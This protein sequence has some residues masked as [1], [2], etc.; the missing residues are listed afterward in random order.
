[1]PIVF[2]NVVEKE[3]DTTVEDSLGSG[4]L[5]PDGETV[6]LC[7]SA[8]KTNRQNK[9]NTMRPIIKTFWRLHLVYQ[10]LLWMPLVGSIAICAHSAQNGPASE[11]SSSDMWS[12]DNVVQLLQ[13]VAIYEKESREAETL[14]NAQRL[15]VDLD[16]LQQR[17]RKWVE[18]KSILNELNIDIEKQSNLNKE[19]DEIQ[20]ETDTF[21]KNG[22]SQKPPYT[23]DFFDQLKGEQD[24]LQQTAKTSDLALNTVKQS[25]ENALAGLKETQKQSRQ[26]QEQFEGNDT[27]SAQWQ[28][29][30]VQLD[31][32]LVE[33]RYQ[34]ERWKERNLKT[35]QQALAQRNRLLEEQASWIKQRLTYIPENLTRHEQALGEKQ[36]ELQKTLSLLAKKKKDADQNWIKAQ[37]EAQKP[38]SVEVKS[39]QQAVLKNMDQW[40]KTYQTAID[41]TTDMLHLIDQQIAAWQKRYSLLQ[42][43]TDHATLARWKKE[44]A[45]RLDVLEQSLFLEQQRQNDVWRQFG[46]AEEVGYK[47]ADTSRLDTDRTEAKALQ[48]LAAFGMEYLTVISA[49]QKLER[50]L[51]DEIEDQLEDIPIRYQVEKIWAQAKGVWNYE[52]GVI[53]DHPLTVKKMIMALTIL[54]FG[55]LLTKMLTRRLAERVLRRPQVKATTAAAIEKLLLYSSYLLVGLFALRMVNIPLTA[56][57]FFGGAIAIGIGFGAQNLINNF[58]SGFIIMGEQPISIGDLIEVEGLLGEV[59]EVG[60]RCTRIRTGENIDILVPNSSFLEKNITNWTLSDR[61]IRA[62]ITLGVVYGSPVHQVQELLLQVCRE[63]QEVHQTPEPFVLFTDFG[64]NALIFEVH[65][66]ITVQRIIERRMIESRMRFRIDEIFGQAG[67]VIAFPQRD[68]HLDIVKPLQI[69]LLDTE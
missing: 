15:G 35:E 57:A 47:Y 29:K 26:M 3:P 1:M 61:R 23:V 11:E 32:Q 22:L 65:F 58:I 33:A 48:Q 52:L 39:R 42:G 19:L 66:W 24:I 53:D 25:A 43:Q 59:K 67:I 30:G 62:H 46:T 27:P 9:R 69:R 31:T 68:V 12:R 6:Y 20:Q 55:I 51:K 40:R 37:T 8:A 4:L 2:E 16:G 14:E 10:F 56:F 38:A 54:I 13:R 7:M 34:L 64:D 60:A 21:Q 44:N 5:I 45:Q 41:Q 17:S 50:R 18:L 28:L 36:K 49:T 63:F